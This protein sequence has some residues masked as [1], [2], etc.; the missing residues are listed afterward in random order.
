MKTYGS[1][2]MRTRGEDFGEAQAATAWLPPFRL[3]SYADVGR[4][5]D[6]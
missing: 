1:T 5:K 4:G 3:I 6:H 2:E